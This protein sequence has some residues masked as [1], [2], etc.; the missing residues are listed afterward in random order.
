M[1]WVEPS[2]SSAPA[3]TARRGWR[4]SPAARACRRRAGTEDLAKECAKASSTPPP[5]ASADARVGQHRGGE[6]VNQGRL[7]D[8][9]GKAGV[10]SASSTTY[11]PANDVPQAKIRRSS[12]EG[13]A[14][15]NRSRCGNPPAA[16]ERQLLTRL[17]VRSP[18]GGSR[19]RQRRILRGR[20]APRTVRARRLDGADT[21][22]HYYGWMRPSRRKVEPGIDVVAEAVRIRTDL[23]AG[24][25]MS[26]ISTGIR[27][28]AV[29]RRQRS[30]RR[31]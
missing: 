13:C 23:R 5:G 19:K 3:R 14:P 24:S 25:T 9:A 10:G 8:R 2:G 1:P 20:I 27:P 29:C 6:P 17:T 30:I 16:G 31:R 12:M 22:R 4:R 11:I 26:V 15:A 18:T 7:R 21:V 28:G